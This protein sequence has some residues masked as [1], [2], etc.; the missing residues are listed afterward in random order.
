[1]GE[2]KLEMKGRFDLSIF[3]W[4]ADYND[5]MTFLDMC[6]TKNCL[7]FGHWSTY[8]YDRII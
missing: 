6:E 5:S 3:R 8:R 4:T 2:V 7:N 1:M